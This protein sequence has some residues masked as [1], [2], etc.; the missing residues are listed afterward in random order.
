[1]RIL[2][3]T[4]LYPPDIADGA[5]YIKELAKRLKDNAEV[6]ILAYA[7]IPEAIS[8]VRIIPISK[9]IPVFTRLIRAFI[10]IVL[11]ARHT[12]YILVYNG[13]SM[14][15]PALLASY[16]TKKP[17]LYLIGDPVPIKYAE[18]HR[19]ALYV[20]TH[21]VQR[22]FRT[23]CLHSV[24]HMLPINASTLILTAPL[25]RPRIISFEPYPHEALHMYE[26]SW[27]THI[28]DMHAF[29]HT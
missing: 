16:M 25:Q 3:V 15:L 18:Q 17:I 1:M 10:R 13:I 24:A 14:E 19:I 6:S 7:H 5:V 26:E 29:L 23:V 4:P 27:Q 8:D 11:E 12:D 9:R 28:R 2:I 22:A 20:H 21:L